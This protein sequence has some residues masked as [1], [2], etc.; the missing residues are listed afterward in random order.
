MSEFF[1]TAMGYF[2]TNAVSQSSHYPSS[3]ASAAANHF[4]NSAISAASMSTVPHSSAM[5]QDLFADQAQQ[6]RRSDTTWLSNDNFCGQLVNL[7]GFKLRVKDVLAIGK[8][9]SEIPILLLI[10]SYCIT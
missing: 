9:L 3:S 10:L 8:Y 5:N 7:A 6:S 2:N 1:K 4:V